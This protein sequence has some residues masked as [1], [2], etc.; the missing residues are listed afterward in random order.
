MLRRIESIVKVLE[1]VGIES[2]GVWPPLNIIRLGKLFFIY[3]ITIFVGHMYWV[4]L[5]F[6]FET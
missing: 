2:G 5:S 6:P 1:R 4:I 3:Y